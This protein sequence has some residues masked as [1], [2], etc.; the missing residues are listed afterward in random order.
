MDLVKFKKETNKL[1]A[2]KHALRV[3]YAAH[4]LEIN[5]GR[6]DPSNKPVAVFPDHDFAVRVLPDSFVPVTI[7]LVN[8]DRYV[9]LLE[10]DN[11]AAAVK[12]WQVKA[13]DAAKANWIYIPQEAEIDDVH[14]GIVQL[15]EHAATRLAELASDDDSPA[16]VRD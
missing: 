6:L 11:F 10:L 5:I 15:L 2:A 8:L 12:S 7:E 13:T 16:A 9:E 1:L 4:S 14:Q 3:H